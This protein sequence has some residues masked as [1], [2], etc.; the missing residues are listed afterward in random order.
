MYGWGRLRHRLWHVQD[1]TR[2]WCFCSFLLA[3]ATHTLFAN[4][5]TTLFNL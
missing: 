5:Y 3:I 1:G 2:V 4:C